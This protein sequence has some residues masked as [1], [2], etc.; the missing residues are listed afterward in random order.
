MRIAAYAGTA[1]TNQF[2]RSLNGAGVAT[3]DSVSL[4]TDITGTLGLANGG[5]NASLS[6]ANGLVAMNSSKR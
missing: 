5:T 6:G 4:S 3:C 1:C 2:V